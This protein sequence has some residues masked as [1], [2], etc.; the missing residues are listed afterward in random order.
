[1]LRHATIIEEEEARTRGPSPQKSECER[2]SPEP[3]HAGFFLSCP[4][5]QCLYLSS[6]KT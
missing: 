4:L 5:E 2:R 6:Y 3:A 1:M